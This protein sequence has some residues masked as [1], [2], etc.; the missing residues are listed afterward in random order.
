MVAAMLTL[1][2]VMTVALIGIAGTAAGHA[3]NGAVVNA[4]NGIAM[5]SSRMNSVQAFNLA[6][7]GEEYALQWLHDQ[8]APPSNTAAFAP[9]LWSGTVSGDREVVTVYSA[10]NTSVGTFSVKIYP[11]TANPGNT[12]K[13]YMIESVGTSGSNSQ[14]L[15]AYVQQD[16]F[17]KYSYF[18]NDEYNNAYWVQGLSQFDGPMHDNSVNVYDPSSPTPVPE[19]LLWFDYGNQTPIYNWNGPDAYSSVASSIAWQDDYVGNYQ[20]PTTTAQ[21]LSIAVGGA[22]TVSTG[23]SFIAM[24]SSST[25]QQTAALGSASVPSST[26][27]VVPNSGG[28]TSAGIYIHGAVNNMILSAPATASQEIEIDQTQSNGKALKTYVTENLASNQT[29]VTVDTTNSN[30]SVTA[31]T[32][33][34]TGTTNGVVYSDG[35]IGSNGPP[36]SGLSGTIANNYVN[37]SGNIVTANQMTLATSSNANIYLNG[38]VKYL[39]QRVEDGNGNPLPE[40]EDSNY[41]TNAGTLGVV[42]NSVIID[43]TNSSGS[44]LDNVQMDGVML[45]YNT[46]QPNNYAYDLAT[47]GT[48]TVNGGYIANQEGIF[49]EMTMTGQQI[50]G[51]ADHYHYD[52]RLADKPPPFY[53]TTGSEYDV[54]SWQRVSSVIQ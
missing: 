52:E 21:W 23:A 48:F 20:A 31:V 32:N 41:V 13:A 44:I 50:A 27:V 49:G 51:F 33:T 5:A 38:S 46:I 53:P 14:I 29:T 10:N 47:R 25:I 18:S 37:G 30:N 26:G 34:Y 54:L 7:A 45:A 43:D 28:S 1:F 3:N 35:S 42:T 12:Q 6:E 9:S 16:S 24:P 4:G 19:N 15:Q 17:S 40:T 36:G 22:S 39:T 11:A 2:M 8:S